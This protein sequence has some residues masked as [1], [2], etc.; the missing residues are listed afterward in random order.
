MHDCIETKERLIDLVFDELGPEAR[1]GALAE[2][3]SCADCLAEYRSMTET[4]RAFDQVVELN[5]PDESYWPGY[6]DRLRERLR[7]APPSW[8]RRWADWIGSFGALAAWPSRPLALAAGLA[9]ILLAFSWWGWQRH[10]AVTSPLGQDGQIAQASPSPKTGSQENRNTIGTRSNGGNLAPNEKK[11]V[12]PPSGGVVAVSQKPDKAGTTNRV[13]REGR[14]GNSPMDG[15]ATT[16]NDQPLIVTASLFAPETIKHFEKAE[17]LLRSFRNASAP[18][19][20]SSEGP[21][22]DS[23]LDLAYEKELSRKLVAQNVQLRQKAEK[24]GNLP[25][26]EALN[27]LEPILL[28]IANLPDKPSADEVRD[29][30]ERMRRKELIASLQIASAPTTT[31]Y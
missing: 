20:A 12:G 24:K 5:A 16:R 23:S 8:K 6:E 27:N 17:I 3:E 11:F 7:Q 30:Q 15:V 19:T 29:I 14:G 25:T 1:R 13:R 28:D 18:R 26:E 4:L 9:A 2:L 31:T 10:R 21:G 22:R